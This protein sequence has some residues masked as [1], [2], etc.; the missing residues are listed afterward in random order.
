MSSAFYSASVYFSTAP[1]VPCDWSRDGRLL[2]FLS[3]DPE[4]NKF[5][6]VTL[7]VDSGKTAQMPLPGLADLWAAR[8]SPDENYLIWAV[9]ITSPTGP[10][11][12]SNLVLR[13]LSA[14][15]QKVFK[16]NAPIA[17]IAWDHDSRHIFY[18]KGKD[19]DR[20]YRMSIETGAEELFS[21][22]CRNLRITDV[23]RDGRHLA[24][25]SHRQDWRI[26]TV[27][28]FYPMR[29]SS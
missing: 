15:S 10:K 11:I 29:K 21:K 5:C 8:I 3:K 27:E 2:Y 25:Q 19:V 24:F 4:T 13:S 23:S 6:H 18:K 26:W 20:L 14:G 22:N 28:N 16:K 1:K 7:D 17:R 9:K 12:T